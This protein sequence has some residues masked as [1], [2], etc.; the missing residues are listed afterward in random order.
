M[1]QRIENWELH[2]RVSNL[3]QHRAVNKFGEGVN[4]RLTMHNDF[5]FVIP[6][7]KQIVRFDH[8][9]RLV[10]QRGTVDGNLGSH[11][12]GRMIQGLGDRGPCQAL[13]VPSSKRTARC[14]Q[15]ETTEVT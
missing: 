2:G 7:A 15:D 6:Q 5:D 12:P 4:Y 3:G 13:G 9:E 8:L 14:R 11:V 10:R 1:R